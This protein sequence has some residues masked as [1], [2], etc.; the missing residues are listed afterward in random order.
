[1][2]AERAIEEYEANSTSTGQGGRL[3]PLKEFRSPQILDL[4]D[5]LFL[6]TGAS[7]IFILGND[8]GDDWARPLTVD[9]INELPVTIQWDGP[10]R[11]FECDSKKV[12]ELSEYLP[13]RSN[14]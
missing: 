4:D 5:R 6:V 3:K 10:D 8:A 11:Q 2:Y 13:S 7:N 12:T 9:E 1:M 14:C